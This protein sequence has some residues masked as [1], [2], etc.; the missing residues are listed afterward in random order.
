MLTLKLK[1]STTLPLELT[2]ISPDKLAEN[3]LKQIEDIHIRHGNQELPLGELFSVRG[4]SANG[5]LILVGDFHSAVGIGAG[6]KAGMLRVD[7]DAGHDV[8][9]GMRDGEVEVT[10]NVQGNLGAE[11]HGGLIRVRGSAGDNVGGALPGSRRGM[12]DGTILVDGSAG[13]FVGHRMR[14]GLIAIRG[15]AGDYLGNGMLAGSIVVD[16][17]CGRYPGAD[18]SRGTICLAE[19]DHAELLPT[20]CFACIAHAPVL[21]MIGRQLQLLGFEN[22]V[23]NANRRWQH[24]SGD[25]LFSGRGEL[26]CARH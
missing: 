17:Q 8:A 3:S 5:D 2:G 16:D 4:S 22:D 15:K 18:M 7:G 11:M 21:G 26:F 6:M 10:G 1:R 20:F 19:S 25:L 13:H 24:F 9:R 12:T 23:W 14:R